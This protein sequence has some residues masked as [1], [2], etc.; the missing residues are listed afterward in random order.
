PPCR[1]DA[2]A[3]PPITH[4]QTDVPAEQLLHDVVGVAVTVRHT[5]LTLV[6]AHDT[7]PS[8]L[9]VEEVALPIT[10]RHEPDGRVVV[11]LPSGIDN[12]A[13]VRR[14][15]IR[16][17]RS[18]AQE[19]LRVRR[20]VPVENLGGNLLVQCLEKPLRLRQTESVRILRE[21]QEPL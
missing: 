6:L 13:A 15:K 7:R 1:S 17:P 4:G 19:L 9:R 10:P 2:D 16:K 18:Q 5:L 20:R 3:V 12:L 14:A 21:I 8:P 11:A